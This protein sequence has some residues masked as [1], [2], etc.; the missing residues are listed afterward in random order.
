MVRPRAFILN[1]LNNKK[2]LIRFL[3]VTQSGFAQDQ[4]T[5]EKMD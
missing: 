4:V 3:V 1:S 2:S 5:P